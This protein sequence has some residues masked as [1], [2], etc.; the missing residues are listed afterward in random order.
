MPR[1]A[2]E[3]LDDIQTGAL[4]PNS[5]LPSLLRMCI[6]LG[7]E[8]GS[9]ALRDWA[10]KELNGYGPDDEFPK[11]RVTCSTLF[12]DGVIPGRR[13]THQQVPIQ[14]IP[15]FARDRVYGD[16]HIPNPV[17][18]L[19]ELVASGRQQLRQSVELGFPG[20]PQ[21][22]A[23]MNNTLATHERDPL[24]ASLNLPPSQVIDRIY[25]DVSLTVFVGILDNIRTTLTQLV[26][27]MRAGTDDRSTL[28]SR[29]VADQA[30]D[31]A[32][33]GNKN[34]IVINQVAPHASALAAAGGTIS[35]GDA[36]PEP[37]A[38]RVGWWVFGIAATI[39]ALATVLLV[40]VH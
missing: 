14:L 17:A 11:Y 19:V 31:V 30:V 6:A 7:G 16:I 5:D 1:R 22:I 40:F 4:D 13:I 39:G 3:L 35:D 37:K 2:V 9:T 18:E 23:L 38:R 15:D 28:P 10:T 25:W 24:L 27:E 32:V 26:A 21:L 8:T 33:R 34:R 29:A 36:Q 12:L 20:A